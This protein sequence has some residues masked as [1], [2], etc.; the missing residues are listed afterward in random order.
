MTVRENPRTQQ[1]KQEIAIARSPSE[2]AQ[3]L[4]SSDS[5]IV[6]M[7]RSLSLDI[8]EHVRHARMTERHVKLACNSAKEVVEEQLKQ[9][10]IVH[11]DLLSDMVGSISFFAQLFKQ[12]QLDLRLELTNQQSC[13]KFHFDNVYVRMLITYFGPTTEYID[14]SKPDEIQRAPLYSLVFLKGQKH[15]GYKRRV[16]HRSPSVSVGEKRLCMIVNFDDW[17]QQR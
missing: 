9:M 10:G 4:S 2:V 7:Q 17:M 16:L 12:S 1:P 15:P 11:T 13:P 14:Q 3:R 6:I 8:A 5:D